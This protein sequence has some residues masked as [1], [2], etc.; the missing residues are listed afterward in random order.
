MK[1][2][3][4]SYTEYGK[5]VEELANKLRDQSFDLIYGMPRGGLPIAVHLSHKLNVKLV[6]SKEEVFEYRNKYGTV[7]LL[8]VDDIVD[9]GSTLENL[10]KNEKGIGRKTAVLFYK[11]H[12]SFVP[13]FYI[14]ET[15]DWIVF[16]W[17]AS[18]EKPNRKMYEDLK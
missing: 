1:K 12:A 3:S 18:F 16:P 2:L 13:D 7:S 4:L 8:A 11:P 6:V 9:T 14:R 17:E 5:M 15:S 10:F